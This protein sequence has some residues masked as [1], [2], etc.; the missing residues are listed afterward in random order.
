M[1][2]EKKVVS[3]EIKDGSLIITVDANKDGQA[4]LSVTVDL[5][6]VADEVINAIKGK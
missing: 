3:M 4:V 1:E 5:A 6:E 2:T